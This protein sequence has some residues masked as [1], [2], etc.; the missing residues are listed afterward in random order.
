MGL[1]INEI[2]PRKAIEFSELKG[3]TIAIDAYN[4]IYQFLSTIRQPDGTPLMDSKKRI[5]SHLSGLFYRNVNLLTEGMK[6]IYIFDGKPPALKFGTNVM[7]SERKEEAKEK[8]EKAKSEEDVEGMGKYARQTVRLT[9]EIID[10]SKRLLEAL[11][12]AVIQAP[13]EGESQAAEISKKSAWAVGSQDYDSLLFGAPR[14][15]QNLT[16][17]RKRKVAT[18]YVY[19]SPELIELEHVLNTLQINLD[20][21]ICLGI[22]A[23]TDY[24]PGGIRGIG[25][26]KALEIVK[27]YREPYLIFKSVESK[28]L[29]QEN[30]FDWQEIYE[31]FHKPDVIKNAEINFPKVNEQ[32]IK[33]ILVEEHDF[34]LERV[35]NTLKK[36][37]ELREKKKQKTLFTY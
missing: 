36:L 24:N 18:G 7:R 13:S 20:Q 33:K 19:I 26:K 30:N 16:L 2:V 5:T 23:G 37:H 9:A 12:I 25:Q 32:E 3:K 28:L 15:I 31:L 27:K 11:G 8:Y 14:L 17:A 21:L 34:S 10:D 6:L 29:E 35:E 4:T 22:L 1:Q